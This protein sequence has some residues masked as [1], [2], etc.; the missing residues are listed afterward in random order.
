MN[1]EQVLKKKEIEEI[2]ERKRKEKQNDMRSDKRTLRLGPAIRTIAS[3]VMSLREAPRS[4]RR[5]CR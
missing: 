5:S 3:S 4:S 2:R 1:N